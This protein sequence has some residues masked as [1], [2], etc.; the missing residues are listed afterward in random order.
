[1]KHLCLAGGVLANGSGTTQNSFLQNIEAMRERRALGERNV[2]GKFS[3]IRINILKKNI[4]NFTFFDEHEFSTMNNDE[5][6][7]C[8]HSI[9]HSRCKMTFP[10]ALSKH[11]NLESLK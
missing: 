5:V 11:F 9:V 10:I 2:V 7:I 6:N 4:L 8:I 3:S 1:M